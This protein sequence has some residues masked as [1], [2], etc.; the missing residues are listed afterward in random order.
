MLHKITKREKILVM[1]AVMSGLFLSALDQ[2]IVGTALPKIVTEFNGLSKLSWVIT[3]YLLTSTITVPIAGKLSDI[4]GR[5]K[6]ITIGIVT[7]V[8]GSMLTGLSWNMLSLIAFRAFQGVGAGI[9]LSN[10]FAII[11]DL[12]VPA[13]RAKWQ[14]LFGGVFAI[15]S[16]VGPLLGG[17]LTDH[18]SWRWCFYINVP[19]GIVSFALISMYMPSIKNPDKKGS[20]DYHGAVLLGL[21]LMSALLGLSFGG[22][23]FAWASWQIIGLLV[24][25][26]AILAEFVRWESKAKDPILP[27]DLFKNP[28]F[29]VSMIMLFLTGMAMFGAIIYLP[30][31][32]QDVQGFSATNSGIVLLPMV[33]GLTITSFLNGQII[34]RT[35]KYKKLAVTGAFVMTGAMFWLS[36]LSVHSSKLALIERMIAMGIG[37]GIIMPLFN[38]IVQ[39]AFPQNRLGVVSA[40][41]QLARSIGSVIGVAIMGSILNHSLAQKLG[42]LQDDKFVQASN[43]SGHPIGSINANSLQHILSKDGQASIMSGFAH[44]PAMAAQQMTEAFHAFVLRAQLAL[45]GAITDVFFL[46][47]CILLISCVAVFFLKEVPLRK[48]HDETPIEG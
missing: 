40:S 43:S 13:E 29:R 44:L 24:A 6:M 45:S 16:V 14:G 2:S 33:L 30:L 26:V 23:E 1:I 34:S 20:I 22:N 18:A 4:F 19:V 3:A 35:G 39:N 31:F 11:G 38:L 17:W 10:A 36:T 32:A 46:G 21:G 15:A 9:L 25:G 8:V 5:R 42:N 27:L 41:T 47:G 7:F 28:I 48:T 12:F 37:I